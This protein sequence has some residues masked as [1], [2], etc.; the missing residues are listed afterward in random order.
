MNILSA[1]EFTKN[2]LENRSLSSSLDSEVL[3]SNIL[4]KDRSWLHAHPEH[5]LQRSDI[6][7]L[8]EQVA[9][10]V[11]GEPIAYI[12][13]KKEFYGRDFAVNPDVLV[14]RPESESFIELLIELKNDKSVPG[15]LH[16]VLDMGTGSGCLAITAKKEFPDML[17]TATDTS[18]GALRTAI[19]NAKQH[20]VSIVFKN[21]SLLNSDKQG[22]D[23][24]IANMPYVPDTMQDRS[25]KAEPAEALFSGSDGLSH[26]RK[27]FKQ[28]ESKHIR[29]VM[30]ESL[31]SQHGDIKELAIQANY[32][33]VKTSGLVQLFSKNDD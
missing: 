22:Y 3:L 2:K 21:Q 29:F 1:L 23:V 8:E 6:C 16:Q 13:G 32:D 27:L 10:R 4:S 9:R 31:S 20:S 30:T 5:A 17:V 18:V 28:L 12:I 15:F 25:I 11:D 33:I 26:Y 24:I 7:K 19:A 14:P